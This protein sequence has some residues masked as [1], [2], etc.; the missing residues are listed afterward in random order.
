[1]PVS[2]FIKYFLKNVAGG[3]RTRP[4]YPPSGAPSGGRVGFAGVMLRS[5]FLLP[6][7]QVREKRLANLPP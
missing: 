2:I 4:L 7:L 1:M 6:V 3:R 5:R